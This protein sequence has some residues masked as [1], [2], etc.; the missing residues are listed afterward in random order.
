MKRFVCFV[1]ALL[2]CPWWLHAQ[3]STGHVRGLITDR[4]EAVI[5]AADITLRN[6]ETGVERKGQSNEAG[7]YSFPSVVPGQYRLIVEYPGLQRFE[8]TF[9]V[10]LQQETL[11]NVVL[12]V[13]ASA[14]VVEVTDLTPV[15]RADSATLGHVLENQRIQQ[16]PINGRSHQALLAT[17]PG[18][19]STGIPQAYGMR[20]NTTATVFD[21]SQ[22]NEIWEGWDFGRP[23]G[24]DAVEELNVEVSNS[25]AKYSQPTTIVMSSKSGTNE[26]HGSA[27]WT[28]RNSGY[29]VARRRQD[30]YEKPPY[31]NRNEYGVSFGGPLVLP[32]YNGKNKTFWFAAWEA[33]RE[34]ENNTEFWTVPTAAMRAGDF[35]GLVDS[36]GRQY[37]IYDP[38]TTDPVT[39]E[40]QQ[41][42]YLGVPNMIDPARL[43]PT[44]KYLFSVTP[45]PTLPGVN[46]LVD[47]NWVGPIRGTNFSY[48]Y[49]VRVDHRFSD[50]DL[51][52]VRYSK[53]KVDET[54]EYP[55]QVMLDGV[56]NLTRRNW[57]NRTL[58]ATWLRVVSPTLT[59][60]VVI[61]GSR[62]I[63]RRGAG[64][65]ET[66]Y[67]ND[68]LGL[69]NPFKAVNWPTF[70]GL[71]LRDDD[72]LQYSGESPF[73]LI[74]NYVTLQDNA[75][76]VL[77]KHE[78]QFGIQAR[79]EIVDK[80]AAP[81][82][83]GF[84]AETLATSLLDPDSSHDNPLATPRTGHGLANLYLGALNYGAQYQRPWFHFRRQEY[85]PYF[86]DT[87]KVT[88]QLTLN[89]GL[90]Y[91][92]RTP[93]HDRD[94]TLLTFDFDRKA[95]VV[96]TSV[97]D[98][99]QRG[100]TL[101]SIL[102]SLRSFGG[103]IISS[104]EA[105]L[106]KDLIHRNWKQ[107]GPRLGFAYRLSS[108]SRP[109]VI[110]GGYRISYYPQKLQDWVGA[111][112]S[113]PPV[114][115]S[116]EN[117]LTNTALSPD[118]LPNYGLRSI[119]QYL[120]GINTP[121]SIIDPTDTRL[122]SRGFDARFLDPNHKDGRVQDWNLT[123][124]REIL[125][126]TLLRV[127]YVG[128][129]SDRQQQW[130]AYNNETPEYIW[131][132][133]RGELLP[134]GEFASVAT[135]PFD[136]TTY[137]DI[138]LFSPVGYGRHN[139]F[140]F[141]IERRYD[142]GFGFQVFY[143]TARTLLTNQDTDGTQDGETILSANQF[144]PG[145]V[146]SD[147][148]ARN[149]FLNYR[150]DTNTPRHQIRW[151]FIVDLPFGR[152]KKYG[153]NASGWV[154]KLIGGWQIAGLGQWRTRYW[155]LPTDI[156]PQSSKEIEE[157][158]YKYPI[159]DCRSGACQPG[160][161]WWN[162]YIPA[163]QI[164]SHD[165]DGKPNGVMGVPDNYKPAAQPLIPWGQT[166]LPANAPADT[167]VSEFWDSNTVWVPLKDGSV[168]RTDF[169]N[170]LH[171]WRNQFRQ[172][173]NQWF[174][175]ASLFKFVS[176]TEQLKLRINLDVFNVFN[177]PN[178]PG[179]VGGDG[180]LRTRNS[181]SAARVMQVSLRLL[182]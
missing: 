85:T 162:G 123:I 51:V 116:F 33:S 105:G 99:V 74:T 84:S 2:C 165:E 50:R 69:P 68:V 95:Y 40:R 63:H 26:V 143:R 139:S 181:G 29:G 10:R 154:D 155:E 89:F 159:Q 163:N 126:Q 32:G 134:T 166:S 140:Q 98:F 170:G 128:N 119:P 131:Y 94:G 161:L 39:G 178:N 102:S 164:N 114:G 37:K 179:G 172:G 149:R 83:G 127:A 7:L 13:G 121:D 109:V 45:L 92:M 122:L 79:L 59:N 72:G 14:T 125:P 107:F 46:P 175:D 8:A 55:N 112:T 90:R 115:A 64:D 78:L 22:V 43:S 120:A 177:N 148:D 17:V 31:R 6:I 5:P 101:P 1:F 138:N 130:V 147:I 100:G 153:S 54:Y 57:P 157:Y 97:D 70:N 124:E 132:A 106:P 76:K 35:R 3:V 152:G 42:S 30:N 117:S 41:I 135:R 146:P 96:G 173:P 81:E 52:Y 12:E 136:Q 27:F 156:Y 108:G 38:L 176:L 36:Q 80:S 167:D 19:D 16:L 21:G 169:D 62:D 77:G 171:P 182:W 28:N 49:S 180:I 104:S 88:Q 58:G 160:Y 91:E 93:L 111:Q 53:G 44:A 23:P 15:I 9:T 144:L 18:I 86:H 4:T 48:T 65:F 47:D 11:V 118:G 137:G 145:A 151:N 24:L 87:W 113:S 71:E 75:T 82:A 66:N 67:T 150:L 60:E 34:V 61:T 73:W 103:D 25:S 110:R 168:E 141:E 20:T 129:Y 158:K 174:Q 142:N 56:S 133:T